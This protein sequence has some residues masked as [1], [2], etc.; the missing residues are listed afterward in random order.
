MTRA[1]G[2]VVFLA[3]RSSSPAYPGAF[4]FRSDFPDSGA[5]RE[6]IRA[7]RSGLARLA[8]DRERPALGRL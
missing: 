5:Q 7:R 2:E 3:L 8:R 6:M 4:T 1:P